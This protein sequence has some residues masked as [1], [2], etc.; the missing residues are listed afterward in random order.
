MHGPNIRIREDPV[1]AKLGPDPALLHAPKTPLRHRRRAVVD[2]HAAR[3]ELVRYFLCLADVGA[4]D[5]RAEPEARRVRRLDDLCEIG[6]WHAGDDRPE[7]LFLDVA[8][9][10]GRVVEDGGVD[11][12]ALALLHVRLTRNE[13]VPLLL[14]VLV[15]S[16]NA[17]VL[18]VVLDGTQGDAL[19]GRRA[20]LEGFGDGGEGGGEGGVDGVGHVD[21]LDGDAD[22]AR[23]EEGA[24]GDLGRDGRNVDVGQD[25]AGV[26]ASPTE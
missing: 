18:H 26:V 12:V 14:R 3:L 2:P 9:G 8:G 11:E 20:D 13:L 22:L 1:L 24:H 7:R 6:I 4:E 15:E 21:A 19:L 10:G 5:R 25:D 16:A 17:L 23:V